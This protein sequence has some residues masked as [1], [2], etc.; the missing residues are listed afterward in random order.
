MNS[1]TIG[2][3][4]SRR[5]RVREW[6]RP[7][8]FGSRLQAPIRVN[9]VAGTEHGT[10]L[11]RWHCGT[12]QVGDPGPVS[13]L[14]APDKP[15]FALLQPYLGVAAEGVSQRYE[16]SSLSDAAAWWSRALESVEQ[17]SELPGHPTTGPLAFLVM[18]FDPTEGQSISVIVPSDIAVREIAGDGAVTAWRTWVSPSVPH[19]GKLEREDPPRRPAGARVVDDGVDAFRMRVIGAQERLNTPGPHKIVVTRE[20]QVRADAPLDLRWILREL[21]RTC[22]GLAIFTVDGL[23][24]A[25]PQVLL[26]RSNNLVR[27]QVLSGSALTGRED[28]PAELSAMLRPGSATFTRHKDSAA[29]TVAALTPHALARPHPSGPTL[30]RLPGVSH[31]VSDVTTVVADDVDTLELLELLHPPVDT[32]GLPYADAARWIAEN[33]GL[34]RG[35][36]TAPVGWLDAQG[37]AVFVVA[38]RCGQLSD[39]GCGMRLFADVAVIPELSVDE[40][41]ELSTVKLAAMCAALGL[42]E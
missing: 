30:R 2:V 19:P 33:E 42:T 29:S 18:P 31:L 24:G 13:R 27:T 37:N 5:A 38:L 21:E 20:V 3:S 36:F 35:R 12:W 22:P 32:V 41:V 8:S 34:D 11:G 25:S 4:L 16:A 23:I 1:F 28:F 39:D 7:R 15:V 9:A 26:Q 14:L 40:A 17:E 10:G 6:G